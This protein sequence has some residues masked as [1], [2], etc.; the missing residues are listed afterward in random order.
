MLIRFLLGVSVNPNMAALPGG[1]ELQNLING[2]S[3]WALL[4]A[5][6]ALIVGAVAWA[7]G[8]HSQNY[9]QAALGKKAV[10]VSAL[11]A[12]II[13]AAPDIINF[14]YSAGQTIH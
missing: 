9:H 4:I 2:L 12:L 10:L 6:G 14:F 8:A 7:V 3:A 11:S 1:Q 13:G 5:L